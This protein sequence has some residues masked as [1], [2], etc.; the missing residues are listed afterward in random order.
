L[1]ACQR[2]SGTRTVRFGVRGW[3]GT[4]GR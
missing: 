1:T 3:L 4:P 2:S